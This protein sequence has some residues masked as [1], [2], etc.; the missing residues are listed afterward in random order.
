MPAFWHSRLAKLVSSDYHVSAQTA[1]VACMFGCVCMYV[2]VRPNIHVRA[3]NPDSLFVHI[4]RYAR[5]T[6]ADAH[7]YTDTY[8]PPTTHAHNH[9]FQKIPTSHKFLMFQKIPPHTN[10]THLLLAF[11]LHIPTCGRPLTVL[12][13]ITATGPKRS[14][15]LT[16]RL[17]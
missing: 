11:T 7:I 13:R 16:K 12:H 9:M 6:H 15:D 14:N 5:D 3:G 1:R 17:H 8:P 2:Y 4:R 10:Y